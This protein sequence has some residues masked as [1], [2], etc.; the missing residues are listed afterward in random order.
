MKDEIARVIAAVVWPSNPDMSGDIWRQMPHR[1]RA[2]EDA[3]RE[4]LALI[5]RRL[6]EPDMVEVVSST[7]RCRTE[8]PW[9]LAR[10]VLAAVAKKLEERDD[11]RQGGTYRLTRA[12]R[13]AG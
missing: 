13:G 11:D 3:A 8:H 4:A 5:S 12:G 10:A 1:R 9:T 6:Q 7:L 2:A